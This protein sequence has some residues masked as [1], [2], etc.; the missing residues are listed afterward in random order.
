MKYFRYVFLFLVNNSCN[1]FT[2]VTYPRQKTSNILSFSVSDSI[3][4]DSQLSRES[5]SEL[6]NDI[7]K[8]T[9]QEVYFSNDLKKIYSVHYSDT[10]MQSKR[11]DNQKYYMMMFF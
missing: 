6:L 10:S 5:I 3:S 8:Q 9:I 2:A 1:G 7:D 4:F 11:N